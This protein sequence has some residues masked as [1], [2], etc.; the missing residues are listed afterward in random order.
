MCATEE[1]HHVSTK[2]EELTTAEDEP[3]TAGHRMNKNNYAYDYTSAMNELAHINIKG[4]C[5]SAKVEGIVKCL[6]KIVREDRQAK[7]IVF[8]E[9]VTMLEMI[10]ELLK[11]ND[12][13]HTYIKNSVVLQK[14]IEQFKREPYLN[15]LIM[16]Y[17]YGANGLN[18]IEATHVLLVEPTLNKSQE[19]QA[20]GRVHRIG[21]T[22]AT[23][24]YRFLIR[25]SIEELV[26]SLFKSNTS[27]GNKSIENGKSCG[28][29]K[30]MVIAIDDVKELFMN[31]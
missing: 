14:K 12:I 20:I 4:E 28:G 29:E 22:K 5:N 24:V 23:Y 2:K 17:S 15:V 11:A 18:I 7:C 31:L 3:A 27:Y 16:P 1:S 19:V 25:G 10:V 6:K 21:Q 8:S 9:H 30:E 26:Y 13:E